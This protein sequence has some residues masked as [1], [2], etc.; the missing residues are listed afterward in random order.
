MYLQSNAVEVT[1]AQLA[2][3]AATLANGGIC[4]TTQDRVFSQSTV[5]DT[6]SLMYLCGMDMRS[7]HWAFKI[8]I[9]AKSGLSGVIFGMVP[10]FGGFAVHSPKLDEHHNSVRGVE[11]FSE[12]VERFNFRHFDD[13][14]GV[15]EAY[16]QEGAISNGKKGKIDC[17]RSK[18][19]KLEHDHFHLLHA[20]SSGAVGEIRK[21]IGQSGEHLLKLG[22]FDKRTA[23]HLAAAEGQ[24]DVVKFLVRYGV[25]LSPVDRWGFTP[26]DDAVTN[27]HHEVSRFLRNK[28]A[29]AN[30]VPM[31]SEEESASLSPTR[32]EFAKATLNRVCSEKILPSSDALK[33]LKTD[34]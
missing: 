27:D 6:I 14:C 18:R 4:P 21:L 2:L 1:C 19:E 11:F 33:P 17:T 7:G 32:Q 9:P 13:L 22:D 3:L 20:A 29:V 15:A 12:L 5:R 26:L 34:S 10:G 25:E 24:Y 8:G 31:L 28:G 23:L 30:S 16:S